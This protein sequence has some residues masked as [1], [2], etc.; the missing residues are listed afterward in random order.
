MRV[1]LLLV[2]LLLSACAPPMERHYTYTPDR[3]VQIDLRLKKV[4]PMQQEGATTTLLFFDYRVLPSGES[5]LYLNA[6]EIELS[7]GGLLSSAIYYDSVASV[8]LAWQEVPGHGVNLPLYAV[9]PDELTP[10]KLAA[11]GVEKFGLRR[12]RTEPIR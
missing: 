1:A 6:G 10:R 2:T 5:P 8:R 3:D 4:A 12:S 7:A 9:F 11:F